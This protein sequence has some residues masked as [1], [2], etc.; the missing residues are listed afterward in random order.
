MEVLLTFILELLFRYFW[1][2]VLAFPSLWSFWKR[3]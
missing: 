3:S 2:R 1:D